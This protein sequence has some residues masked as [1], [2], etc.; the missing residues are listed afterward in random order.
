MISSS[1]SLH[2]SLSSK[3]TK[4]FIDSDHINSF[5]KR[6][7][8]SHLTYIPDQ[9]CNTFNK[10]LKS[11]SQLSIAVKFSA[12]VYSPEKNLTRKLLL[13]DQISIKSPNKIRISRTDRN[14]MQRLDS[15]DHLVKK[16]TDI[17]SDFNSSNAL[18]GIKNY[19]DSMGSL[20]KAIEKFQFDDITNAH[21][22]VL[23][24]EELM[25]NDSR[26]IRQ[27]ISYVENIRKRSKQVWKF[28]S[29]AISRKTE[30][31][32][33]SIAKKLNEKNFLMLD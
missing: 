19:S 25:R 33:A 20:G 6:K 10:L 18:N 30:R 31:L 28:Q 7:N 24:S 3:K 1:Q 23:E 26:N 8:P 14:K 4:R 5:K 29:H 13:K 9:T 27:Q 32:V 15:L 2:R 21:E 17:R 12:P 22:E 16:C 11:R